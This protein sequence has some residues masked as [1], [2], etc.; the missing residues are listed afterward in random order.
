MVVLET[1][2]EKLGHKR[3]FFYRSYTSGFI[4]K[5][6]KLLDELLVMEKPVIEEGRKGFRAADDWHDSFI[7]RAE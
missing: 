4:S 1:V 5:L 6:C 7:V 2:R 3:F